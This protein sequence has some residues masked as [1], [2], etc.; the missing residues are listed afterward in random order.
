[1][2]PDTQPRPVL[3]P[4]AWLL[5]LMTA[6]L[7]WAVFQADYALREDITWLVEAGRRLINGGHYISDVF[8]VNPPLSIILYLPLAITTDIHHASL[9]YAFLA[10]ILALTAIFACLTNAIIKRYDFLSAQQRAVFVA[11]FVLA[12]TVLPLWVEFGQREQIIF[13]GILPMILL[14]TGKTFAPAIRRGPEFWPIMVLGSVAMLIKP[15]YGIFAAAIMLIRMIRQRRVSAIFDQ[16]FMIL[17]ALAILYVIGTVILIPDYVFDYLPD[18]VQFYAGS[19]SIAAVTQKT[20][21]YLVIFAILSAAAY[22]IPLD[23]RL[24]RCLWLMIAC[25]IL[26][27]IPYAVQMKG[28]SYHIY[29]V[30]AFAFCAATLM[31]GGALSLCPRL[32]RSPLYAILALI[33]LGYAVHP[34]NTRMTTH[35]DY[36]NLPLTTKLQQCGHPDCRFFMYVYGANF[37]YT[38]GYYAHQT[39]ASRFSDFW[40]PLGLYLEYEKL[41]E[42][43]SRFSKEALDQTFLRHIRMV[44]E[45]I[46]KGKPD[47]IF[48]CQN[49]ANDPFFDFL[50]IMNRDPSFADEWKNY[51]EEETF[52][53]DRGAYYKGTKAG[54]SVALTFTR[55]TRIA[56]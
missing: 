51:R 56:P 35:G 2:T 9:P 29:P 26:C 41:K 49:C 32:A 17:E 36:R 3:P 12:C 40:I 14:Q 46:K 13:M 22:A 39:H 28:F 25:G 6:L 53:I 31:I 20:I 8:E 37:V 5:V 55:Y 4:L 47:Q 43:T 30:K 38:T 19:G 44:T 15:H 10:Y 18:V 52:T 33:A 11:G 21:P 45:D 42:G 16:D 27:L 34:L 48:I 23:R 24:K 50:S 7:P 54:T 1:M